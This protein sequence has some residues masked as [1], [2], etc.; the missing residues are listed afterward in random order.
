MKNILRIAALA[1]MALVGSGLSAN[2]K[3]EWEFAKEY[4]K[5]VGSKVTDIKK[6]I[7]AVTEAKELLENC[8]VDNCVELKEHRD[9]AE[10][11]YDDTPF[12]NRSRQVLHS[13]VHARE[14]YDECIKKHCVQ[15]QNEVGTKALELKEK[16]EQAGLLQDAEQ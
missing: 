9:S 13:L 3:E 7:K 6:K 2:L 10:K 14:K 11:I 8:I 4:A 1:I 12:E 16:A 5:E 15:E